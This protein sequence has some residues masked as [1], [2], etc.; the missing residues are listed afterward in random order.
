VPHSRC[1]KPLSHLSQ[2]CSLIPTK[3][4]IHCIGGA[5]GPAPIRAALARSIRTAS[6]E[7]RIGKRQQ[8]SAW[9]GSLSSHSLLGR[10]LLVFANRPPMPNGQY[11]EISPMKKASA[12]GRSQL[13]EAKRPKLSRSVKL[14]VATGVGAC[15][16]LGVGLIWSGGIGW[17]NGH[18][19]SFSTVR[20][21]ETIRFA[22]PPAEPVKKDSTAVSEV[23]PP[24]GTIRRMEAISGSFSRK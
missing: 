21:V 4:K 7:A 1:L 2:A 14:A 15:L 18:P 20:P 6:G 3:F 12:G 22:T 5:P 19:P 9:I 8:Q 16:L 10:K 24:Q 13:K 17:N 23:P 11:Y